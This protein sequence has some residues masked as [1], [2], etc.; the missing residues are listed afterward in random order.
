[1]IG[2][3]NNSRLVIGDREN[4][5]PLI[6]S[7]V[8]CSLR[9]IDAIDIGAV[10]IKVSYFFFTYTPAYHLNHLSTPFTHQITQPPILPVSTYLSKSNKM[11]S[12]SNLT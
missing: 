11:K 2:G 1:M 7:S 9:H 3:F 8:I 5:R 6:G 10:C 4:I 12:R